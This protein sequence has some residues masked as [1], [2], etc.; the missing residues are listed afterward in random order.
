MAGYNFKFRRITITSLIGKVIVKHKVHLSKPALHIQQY[1]LQFGFTEGVSC[2]I[3]AR[4]LTEFILHCIYTK[5]PIYI[6]YMDASKVFDV[7]DHDS[8]LVHLFKQSIHGKV[9]SCYN[10]LYTSI[11]SHIM[12]KGHILPALKEEQGIQKGGV[13]ST[14]IFKAKANHASND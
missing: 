14:G 9:W 7:V 11:T 10:S 6:T 2:N 13:S 3:G 1:P 5:V 8:A 12:W 4:L